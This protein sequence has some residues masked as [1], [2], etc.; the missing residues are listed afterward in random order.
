MQGTGV[1][2]SA[3][4]A[5]IIQHVMRDADGGRD[6]ARIMDVA[7]GAAGAL[8]VGRSAMVVKLQRDADDVITLRLQQRS[9]HRRVDAAGHGDHDTGVFGTAV[10]VEAVAHGTWWSMRPRALRPEWRLKPLRRQGFGRRDFSKKP[11]APAGTLLI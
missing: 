8:A 6:I 3:K 4:A 11:D 7:P 2:P 10:E 9:R 5:L 1:S